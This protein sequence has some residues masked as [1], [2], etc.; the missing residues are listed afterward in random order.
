MSVLLMHLGKTSK[1]LQNLFQKQYTHGNLFLQGSGSYVT[2]E[3]A[4][5]NLYRIACC[6]RN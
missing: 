4:Q 2:E 3:E 5:V 6:W 1:T